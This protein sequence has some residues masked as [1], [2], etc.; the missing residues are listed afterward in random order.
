MGSVTSIKDGRRYIPVH[1]LCSSLSSIICEIL[2]AVHALTGCDTTSA[3]FGIGKQSVF[4]LINSSSA[5]LSDLSQLKDPDLESSI[6]VA[7][8][9]VQSCMTQKQ[10]ISLAT[11]I[12][13]SYVSDLLPAK[14][15]PLFAFHQVNR[16]LNNTSWGLPFKQ[17]RGW[18]HTKQNHQ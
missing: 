18:H 6:C 15:A 3:I 16:H 8:K 1:D 11:P 2:P 17:R 13:I 7:R 12:W 9:F 10:S 14:T 4:K 5:E